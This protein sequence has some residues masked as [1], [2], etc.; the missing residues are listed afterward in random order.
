M[1]KKILILLPIWGRENI[2]KICFDNL[3]ELQKSYN[4]EV[5]CVVSEQW[6]KVMAFEYGFKYCNAS[7]D[8]LGTKMNIGIEHAKTMQFDYLMNLGSDDI[9]TK[10]LFDAY[11]DC[12][13]KNIGIFGATK[14]TFIDS[15]SKEVKVFDYGVMIGAGRCIRKDILVE[16]TKEGMYDKIQRGLDLN[17]MKRFIR[18]SNTE[19]QVPLT[20]IYD[21]KSK[22]NIWKFNE[23]P[24]GETLDFDSA[25]KGLSTK[26]IDAILEL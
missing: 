26:Q 16:N 1:D 4:I 21:I 12:F 8:C 10:D 6:A 11:E 9:I 20:A 13:N 23:L 18:V 17:S 19:V 15:E 7:N 25:T 2:V 5:L 22:E 3:K 24:K 14:A